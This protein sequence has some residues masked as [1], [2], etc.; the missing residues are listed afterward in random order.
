MSNIIYFERIKDVTGW[1]LK[2]MEQYI[3]DNGWK[4][5]RLHW[6]TDDDKVRIERTA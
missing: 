1:S 2:A 6:K 5:F 4:E 3:K